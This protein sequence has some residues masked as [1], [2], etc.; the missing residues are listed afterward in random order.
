MVRIKIFIII[1]IVISLFTLTSYSTLNGIDNYY[2]IISMGIDEGQNGLLNLS[3]QV[4]SNDESSSSSSSTSQSSSSQIYSVEASSIDEGITILNNYL[5]KKINLSHCSAIIFSE[6]IAT[7]GLKTYFNTLNNNTE[8]RETCNLIISSSTAYELMKNVSNSGEIFS[9]R[10]FD[11]LTNSE[12]YTGYTNEST[13]GTFSKAL[14]TTHC[15]PTAI[16]ALVSND[17]VQT[18]GI[19]VFKNEYM[20]GHIDSLSSIAHLIMKKNLKECN[21]TIDSPFEENEKIDL[22]LTLYKETNIAIELI[23][24]T[25][26]FNIDIYPEANITSSGKKFDFINSENIKLVEDA[27]NA[28]LSSIVK[29]Y[30]YDITKNFDSDIV[31]FG[32]LYESKFLTEEEFNKL[33]WKKI[34]KDSFFKINVNTKVNSSNLFN[35]E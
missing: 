7:S 19:A 24:G 11:Y 22:N 4:S 29:E 31:C 14:H 35:K 6:K 5:N 8:L 23:N 33:E 10:L 1:L 27:A 20:I 15:E 13:I 32:G 25:P 9:S 26:F 17:V 2:F 16:Y 28:Y 34:F 12:K 18:A 30:L 21:L 3:V